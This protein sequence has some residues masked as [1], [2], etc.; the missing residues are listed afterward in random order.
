MA[1]PNESTAGALLPPTTSATKRS[2]DEDASTNKRQKTTQHDGGK[3][4]YD[5]QIVAMKHKGEIVAHVPLPN[6]RSFHPG[7]V[8]DLVEI[9]DVENDCW[10][11]HYYDASALCNGS[12][13]QNWVS[14]LQHWD[15]RAIT[16]NGFW[17]SCAFTDARDLE[18]TDYQDALVDAWMKW[19]QEGQPRG[20]LS[21]DRIR[22]KGLTETTFMEDFSCFD[23]S[24]KA[25]ILH[26]D[27]KA[28]MADDKANQ[29]YYQDY[30]RGAI[31]ELA[32][33]YFSQH[34]RE[35]N[36]PLTLSADEFCQKYHAH[37]KKNS[38][39]YRTK[40]LPGQTAS[41]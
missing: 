35:P 34:K 37:H 9:S 40:K 41:D 36:D 31:R 15:L 26:H 25:L 4:A 1:Q 18:D 12:A 27:T 17:F 8:K 7:R 5:L 33:E 23:D 10:K 28:G 39:C 24:G 6:F 29:Q 20:T 21:V 38:P 30:T 32:Q 22:S 16:K 19:L 3:S 13:V 14:W 2:S 11:F